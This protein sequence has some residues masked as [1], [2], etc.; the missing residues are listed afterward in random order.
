MGADD[1]GTGLGIL[2]PPSAGRPLANMEL[3]SD[4]MGVDFRPYMRQILIAI[5]RNWL[6]VYPEAARLGQRGETVLEF[7]I[8]KARACHEGNFL[9]RIGYQGARSIGGC[10]DQRL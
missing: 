2:L 5:K 8:A 6:A 1:N 9:E 3:K 10:G 7:A 4:P